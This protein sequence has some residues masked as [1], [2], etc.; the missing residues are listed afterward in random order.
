MNEFSDFTHEGDF[1]ESFRALANTG[2]TRVDKRL[3]APK[4]APEIPER[5]GSAPHVVAEQASSGGGVDMTLKGSKTLT[6]TD[7]LLTIVFPQS[8]E[9][10]IGATTITLPAIAVSP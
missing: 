4:V 7:G 6:S 5:E 9:A 10:V 8:A 2:G 1:I 3:P